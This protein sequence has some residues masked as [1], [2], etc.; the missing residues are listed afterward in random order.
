MVWNKGMTSNDWWKAN[1]EEMLKFLRYK[2]PGY[3]LE[4]I[5]LIL[6]EYI[7]YSYAKGSLSKYDPARGLISSWACTCISFWLTVRANKHKYRER[8]AKMCSLEGSDLEL[9]L[10]APDET[11]A[12]DER[13]QVDEIIKIVRKNADEDTIGMLD[14]FMEGYPINVIAKKYGV[15]SDTITYKLRKLRHFINRESF[16]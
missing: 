6:H 13:I 8:V 4:E 5:R 2:L 10:Q 12:T 9:Y 14:M 16:R 1:Y 3:P 15:C 7:D 11:K